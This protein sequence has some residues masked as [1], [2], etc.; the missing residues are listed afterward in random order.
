VVIRRYRLTT[1]TEAVDLA[2]HV[3][4]LAPDGHLLLS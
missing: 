4:D 2:L 1:K 3:V